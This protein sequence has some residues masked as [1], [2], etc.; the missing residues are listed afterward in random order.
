M[1]APDVVFALRPGCDRPV[2]SRL[3]SGFC[4]IFVS[5]VGDGVCVGPHWLA[6]RAA[7]KRL[8][9]QFCEAIRLVTASTW[10]KGS[11]IFRRVPIEP[12]IL[13]LAL[14]VLVFKARSEAFSNIKGLAPWVSTGNS[15]ALIPGNILS[16]LC[17]EFA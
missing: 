11:S 16:E 3:V 4:A 1:P 14:S 12:A 6:Y 7:A 10:F 17:H 5:A 8:S 2:I 9:E 13:E 15:I